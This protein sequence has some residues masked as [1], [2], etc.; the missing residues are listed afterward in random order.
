MKNAITTYLLM[1]VASIVG[2][3]LIL[4]L[5]SRLQA[6]PAL[7]G[8]WLLHPQSSLQEPLTA[9]IEQSGRFVRI[10]FNG[11][12]FIEYRLE[13]PQDD[14]SDDEVARL[15]REDETLIL[16]SPDGDAANISRFERRI[17]N[18]IDDGIILYDAKRTDARDV[19][20]AHADPD[21]PSRLASHPIAL[22]I[23]Q[24]AIIIL[25][26]RI[27]GAVATFFRQPR[28]VGEMIAGVML[29]PSLLGWAFPE[30]SVTL[31]PADSIPFLSLLA[32]L[33][34]I[35][36]LFIIGLELNPQMLR[37]RG[38]IAVVISHASIV[39]PFLLGGALVL[40]LYGQ[41]FHDTPQMRFSSVALFIGAAM[42]ITA[43]PMLARILTERNLHKTQVGAI[44]ITCAAVDDVSAWC[45]LAFVIGL[46]R[47]EGLHQA[48]GTTA[49]SAV[50][51]VMMVFAVRPF[52]RRV[53]VYYERE[54]RLTTGVLA[55]LV[56]I[57]LC[58]SLATE[59]IGIHA[60]FGAFMA[61]AIMPKGGRFVRDVTNRI[62]SFTL[63]VLLP[64]FF[65]FTGLKTRIGLINSSELLMMTALIIAVACIGKFSGSAIAAVSCGLKWREASAIGILMNTRGLMELV[66]LNIGRELGVITD[67]V[68][69][70]MVL[71]ALATTLITT[72]I[73]DLV[74]PERLIRS[75]PSV[76]PTGRRHD[77]VLIPISLPRSGPAM[78]RLADLIT[79]PANAARRV[80]GLH[81]R[82]AEEHEAYTPDM[83]APVEPLEVLKSSAEDIGLTID[84]VS[85]VSRDAATDIAQTA[86]DYGAGLILMGFHKPV[87]GTTILGGTV[88]RVLEE[89]PMDVAVL[90]DRGLPERPAS[91]LVP[92]MD[93][94]H[95]RLALEI[96]A[97]IARHS[98]AAVTVLH[99]VP[100]ST[101]ADA[102]QQAAPASAQ[103]II[104]KVFADRTK[105]A[106]VTFKAN[107][108]TD[109]IET[110][111]Q[112]CP[113]F[114][115]VVIGTME[116]W[117]LRSQLF[118]WRAER[119]ARDCPTSMLIVRRGKGEKAST[120]DDD[121]KAMNALAQSSDATK[122][123]R[124]A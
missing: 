24:L 35:F 93:S 30:V 59:L 91:I 7:E 116:Q 46:A 96:A 50:Y 3:W 124:P 31:F 37:N 27:L 83:A 100:P 114:D 108:S 43:F 79:G 94:E 23:A 121:D 15:I 68:F 97:T 62:Q 29:G 17:A 109:P 76:A 105:P 71:M 99:V 42:S 64:I 117:G 48:I 40:F 115:L 95:D 122:A 26:S 44:S 88:H 20:L 75:R 92:Y 54:G 82:R 60:L 33:G 55:V 8:T 21:T 101:N 10:S 18:K 4:H 22:L 39:A 103:A 84:P 34:V 47:A 69:A 58:S 113:P 118:G 111:L 70:M 2:L 112:H 89:A 28:V 81:L 51:I 87:I 78:V 56:I 107:A 98:R 67:A 90:L 85:F 32:Q 104:D 61:G 52:L 72:P 6:P 36:F 41:V 106:P 11:G 9:T 57:V 63:I 12:P 77:V 14:D 120:V 19:A 1:F 86:K 119:I 74:Y 16:T 25:A 45:L 102:P 73:L 80:I 53:E 65:A 13:S 66:I 49:M 110:V 38:H 5:G 123:M